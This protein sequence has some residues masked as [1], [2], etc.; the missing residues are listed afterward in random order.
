MKRIICENCF[1]DEY[2]DERLLQKGLVY[3]LVKVKI[4]GALLI[5][6]AILLMYLGVLIIRR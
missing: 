1:D 6:L 2:T 3:N 4:L 5:V